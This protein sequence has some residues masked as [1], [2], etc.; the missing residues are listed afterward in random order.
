MFKISSSVVVAVLFVAS[1]AQAAEKK[2]LAEV[3]TDK[4]TNETQQMLSND[5]NL[6]LV[7]VIP[8]EFWEVALAQDKSVSDEDRKQMID[9]LDGNMIVGVV[10]AQISPFGAFR[11][12]GEDAVFDALE[13][14]YVPTD[15]GPT[16]LKLQKRVDGDAQLIID[17]MK[18][19]LRAA[20]GNLGTNFH[21]FICEDSAGG[22]RISPYEK[23]QIAVHLGDIGDL[24]GGVA[25]IDFPLDSLY[26]PRACAKCGKKAHISWKYCPL[27][28]QKHEK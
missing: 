28:G 13:V 10:R 24:E 16:R 26:I 1:F 7:W 5:N 20:M 12:Q 11:F 23:G 19:M 27:C 8:N 3:S 4:L 9:A 21:L 18:P 2:P 15:G 22:R 6:N 14:N 25:K 17:S